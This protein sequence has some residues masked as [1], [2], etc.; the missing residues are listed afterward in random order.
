MIN[1]LYIHKIIAVRY[2]VSGQDTMGT[3]SSSSSPINSGSFIPCRIEEYNSDMQYNPGG[4]RNF[5]ST[6]IYI[7][8][9]YILELQDRIYT[10]GTSEYLGL[11]RGINPAFGVGGIIDHYEIIL[12]NK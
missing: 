6:I 11:V 7:P 4:E 8:P 2:I 10:Y 1:N 5:N 3:F 9:Q 12:E